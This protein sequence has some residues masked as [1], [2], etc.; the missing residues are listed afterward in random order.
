MAVTMLI[1]NRHEISASLFAPGLHDGVADRERVQRGDATTCT[2]RRSWRWA[3][4]C[5][6]MTLIVN[7]IARWL[8]WQVSRKAAGQRGM[9]AAP[10][11]PRADAAAA[12]LRRARGAHG[13]RRG[14]RRTRHARRCSR[15]PRCSRRCRCSS[16]SA[17]CVRARRQLA[18]LELLHAACRSR[19]ARRGGGMANAHRRH[20]DPRRHRVPLRPADRHRRRPVLRRASRGAR[21]ATAC[22]SSPTCSTACRRS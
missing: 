8:V 13:A 10:P 14:R 19:S 22:A 12:R 7:G 17:I 6:V 16:S 4:C 21:L 5:F 2:C 11:R 3:S 9:T 1:G 15:S 18:E 20:T